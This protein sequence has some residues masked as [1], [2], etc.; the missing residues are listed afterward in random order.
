MQMHVQRPASNPLSITARC[1]TTARLKH[2]RN[3]TRIA[4]D[5]CL[6]VDV[7]HVGGHTGGARDIVQSQLANI[8]GQLQGRRRG[9][10]EGR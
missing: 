8:G 4:L 3:R 5:G 10:G 6:A 7:A 9:R 2:Q 1:T